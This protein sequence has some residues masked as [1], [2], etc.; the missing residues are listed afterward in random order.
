MGNKETMPKLFK[1]PKSRALSP[2]R[3]RL[4]EFKGDYTQSWN[5]YNFGTFPSKPQKN[6]KAWL[7]AILGVEIHFY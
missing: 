1:T 4:T 7:P 2:Q 6:N 3:Q 5:V